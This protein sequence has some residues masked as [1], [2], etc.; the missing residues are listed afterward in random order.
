MMR[1]PRWQ[2]RPGVLVAGCAVLVVFA[3]CSSGKSAAPTTT[4]KAVTNTTAAIV[5]TTSSAPPPT[6]TTTS[7]PAAPTTTT[8]VVRTLLAGSKYKVQ[9]G[10]SLFAIAKSFGVTTSELIAANKITDPN[11]IVVGA[12]LT[13]PAHSATTTT[14]AK[15]TGTTVK[16]TTTTVKSTT[17]TTATGTYTVKT[18]D[19]LSSIAAK[20]SVTLQALETANNITDPNKIYVGQVLHIPAH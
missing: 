19:T 7:I 5:T 18:G 9:P 10:D 12:V 13:I 16:S 17:T 14:T 2:H 3:S 6:A 1:E 11:K 8:T 15:S 4:T 20:F